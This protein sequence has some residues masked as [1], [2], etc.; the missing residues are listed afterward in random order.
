MQQ[1]KT[2]A[3]RRKGQILIMEEVIMFGLGVTI[4]AGTIFLFTYISDKILEHVEDDQAEEIASYVQSHVTTLDSIG[5]TKCYMTVK[6][7]QSIGRQKYTILG[8]DS[9]K[10]LL[11]H[12]HNRIWNEK[13]LP[14]TLSGME[15]GSSMLRLEYNDGKIIL[16]GVNNY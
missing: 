6:I 1:T 5:C 15:E 9:K 7:P 8:E 10:T 16:R 14:L 12:D 11:I 3:R 4:I 2:I 13:K